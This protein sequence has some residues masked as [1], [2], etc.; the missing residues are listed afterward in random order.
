MIKLG[1]LQLAGFIYPRWDLR[2]WLYCREAAYLNPLIHPTPYRS[3][4]QHYKIRNNSYLLT[5]NFTP[6]N[7]IP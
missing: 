2:G 5:K 7:E 1:V 3:I 4:R 6:K